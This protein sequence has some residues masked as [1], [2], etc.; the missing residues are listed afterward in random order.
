MSLSSLKAAHARDGESGEEGF[1]TK[2]Y[3][4]RL[5]ALPRGPSP[6]PFLRVTHPLTFLNTT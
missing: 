3:T 2:F 4:E 6:Y 5:E 1:S